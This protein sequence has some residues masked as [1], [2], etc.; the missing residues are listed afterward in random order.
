MF[1]KVFYSSDFKYDLNEIIQ[2]SDNMVFVY[3]N[4]ELNF[5]N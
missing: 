3:K 4:I 2:Y 1:V 5:M